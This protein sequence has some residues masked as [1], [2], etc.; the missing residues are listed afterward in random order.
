[1]P[2][3]AVGVDSRARRSS[4]HGLRQPWALCLALCA[5]LPAVADPSAELTTLSLE[6]LL[7]VTII[8]ASKYEQK[9][10]EAAA[11]VSVITRQEI[12]AF[13]WRTLAEALASLPGVS[14][15]YDRQNTYISTRGFGL[16][17]DFDTRVLVMVDGNRVNNPTFDG[18]PF[19]RE[20]PIDLD[21]IERVEFIPGPGG[22]VYGQN[23]ML[24]VVNVITRKG[25]GLAGAEL[26]A[27]Y[28]DPQALR[29]GRASWGKALDDG[30]DVMVSFSGMH[31]L[32]EDRYYRYG[33]SGMAGVAYDLDGERDRQFFGRINHGPW[34]LE[35][36]H[37][38]RRKDSPTGAF[39]SDPLESGQFFDSLLALT[40]LQYEQGVADDSLHVSVR[41]FNGAMGSGARLSY[42][43]TFLHTDTQSRWRGAEL[44]LLSTALGG[45]KLMVGIE[46]QDN[47]RSDQL[48]PS[49][50]A[51]GNYFVISNP[52]YRVGI[53]AQD[54]WRMTDTLAATL[55][56]RVDNNDETG[57][58]SSPR[59][60]LIWQ[61]TPVTTF[62]A[63]YGRAYRAPNGYE[64]DYADGATQVANTALRGERIDTLELVADQRV[65]RDLTL[66]ASGYHWAM[67]DLIRQGIDPSSGLLQYQSGETVKARGLE[68]SADKTWES[69]YRL[70]D[71]VSV[72]DASYVSGRALL[73]SP[74]VLGKLN[75]SGPL[76]WAG[77]RMGYELRYDSSRLSRDGTT[78]GGY[79][80]SN[81]TFSTDMLAKGLE[82]SAGFYNLFDKRYAQPTAAGSWQNAIEQDGRSARVKLTYGF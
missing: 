68:L 49:V 39:F 59:L 47:V 3:S 30:T 16:P 48:V 42:S 37:G 78:L 69:G 4:R 41:V 17:G 36:V 8:G 73:N 21:L 82:L 38:W 32:G 72:Q 9:Q 57:T 76:P 75:L 66:R 67:R 15:T 44:R 63:L 53:Y 50:T 31:A 1:M 25:A 14:A 74:E 27:A 56:L 28:Q 22:A 52:G 77:L 11:A 35:E 58:Q 80:L 12:Q 20:F 26:A 62:K 45:H 70:R 61:G 81:L 23:A 79:T 18:G 46:G 6:Q 13:G 65:G 5:A 51:P 2:V 7:D 64:R 55:G 19:G 33:A 71:S 54:E 29:E 10:G 40:Q 24:G 43:G 34:T 60:A